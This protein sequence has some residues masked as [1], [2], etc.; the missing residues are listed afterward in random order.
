MGDKVPRQIYY[1]ERVAD[2]DDED[3][4]LFAMPEDMRNFI[5]DAPS[6]EI[7]QNSVKDIAWEDWARKMEVV[8]KEMNDI[9]MEMRH[10]QNA[11]DKLIEERT[12]ADAKTAMLEEELR[13]LKAKCEQ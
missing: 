4:A 2:L 3:N 5:S 12:A 6:V 9:R 10:M 8:T 11:T 7:A 1:A 13:E